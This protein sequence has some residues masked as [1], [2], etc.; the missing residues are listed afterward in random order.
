[1]KRSRWILAATAVTALVAQRQDTE[2]P[3]KLQLEVNGESIEVQLDT[4]FEVQIDGKA[5]AMRL[6]A[7]ATRHFTYG[8]VEFD[9]PSGFAFE[10]DLENEVVKLWNLDGSSAVIMVQTYAAMDI[11]TLTTLV[12]DEI[13][14]G[15]ESMQ[16]QVKR[17][18][19]TLEGSE[20]QA[21]QVTVRVADQPIQQAILGF[22]AEDAAIVIILQDSLQE[23]GTNSA[24]FEEAREMFVSSFKVTRPAD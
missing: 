20:Y 4:P 13:V 2:P 22:A 1:M 19:I 9:Y 10:A 17:E 11:D 16:A 14:T 21:E 8:G 12:V 18:T 3:L 15:Y 7:S 24:E 6:S 23:D 5:V